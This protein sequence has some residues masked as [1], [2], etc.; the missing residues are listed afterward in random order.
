MRWIYLSP[1]LDD[2]VFSAGGLMYD[3]VQAGL[4]VEIWTFMCGCPPERDVSPFAQFLHE[5]WGF[6]S[7]AETIRARRE[8]DRTAAAILGA[9][10]VHLD[11]FDCIYRRTPDGEWLYTAVFVPPRPED[12]WIP[13]KIAET[14]AARLRPDDVVV[15]QLGL[16]L[17]VDH[18]LVRQGAE[19]LG[20]TLLYDLDMPY[21]L[22]HR[23]EAVEKTAGMKE[24]V[25]FITETGLE[26]WKEAALAYKS[27][28]SGLGELFNTSDK[29]QASLQEYR[30]EC[31]GIRLL[32]TE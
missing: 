25:L 18:I 26:R 17:H 22:S 29:V 10:V 28:I 9:D 2:A 31:G 32:G 8:E 20:R 12:A 19:L 4:P 3:Q 1:H 27:Q 14:L 21:V 15:C 6:G 23:A 16:G 5:Q 24:S 30:A 13:P 11:F 7:A